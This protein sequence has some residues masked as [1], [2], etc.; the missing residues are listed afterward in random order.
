MLTMQRRTG[1]PF[2]KGSSSSLNQGSSKSHEQN[3]VVGAS[4]SHANILKLAVSAQLA[5]RV[6]RLT[7]AFRTEEFHSRMR[8]PEHLLDLRL[9]I[10]NKTR[11]PLTDQEHGVAHPLTHPTRVS[12]VTPMKRTTKTTK[13]TKKAILSTMMMRMNSDFLVSLACEG[14]QPS[15]PM[16]SSSKLLIQ[17][18]VPVVAEVAAAAALKP[19]AMQQIWGMDWGQAGFA[20]TAR[21]LPKNVVR[22]CTPQPEKGRVRS[23]GLS[24][25]KS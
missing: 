17:V 4:Y 18:A 22:Q 8:L 21:I 15:V 2:W 9:H 14:N 23:Y 1:S 20:P 5:A 10:P 16:F 24:I 7:R 3:A 13:M 12:R 6:L 11:F 25:R 19:E